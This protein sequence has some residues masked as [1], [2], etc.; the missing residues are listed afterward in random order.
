VAGGGGGAGGPEVDVRVDDALGLARSH[1]V[2]PEELECEEGTCLAER[3]EVVAGVTHDA[4]SKSFCDFS[5][6]S[7]GCRG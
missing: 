2:W 6:Y 4:L 3:L 1:G 7:Y 5:E